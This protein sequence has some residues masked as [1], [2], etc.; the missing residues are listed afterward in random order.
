MGRFN[1]FNITCTLIDLIDY[2]KFIVYYSSV[3]MHLFRS[4]SVVTRADLMEQILYGRH[5]ESVFYSNE[6]K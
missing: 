2:L 5:L 6:C 4:V 1:K 3:T